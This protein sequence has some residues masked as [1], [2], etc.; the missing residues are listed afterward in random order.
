MLD[1]KYSEY[2]DGEGYGQSVGGYGGEGYSAPQNSAPA[3][4]PA[5]AVAEPIQEETPL[6]KEEPTLA[7]EEAAEPTPAEEPECR[8]EEPQQ[9]QSQ[10]EEP[11]EEAKGYEAQKEQAHEGFRGEQSDYGAGFGQGQQ[12]QRTYYSA[13]GRP[14]GGNGESEQ[15]SSY[16]FGG[17][18]PPPFGQN[19]YGDLFRK[20]Q[21]NSLSTL[22]LVCGLFSIIVSC[23][24]GIAALICGGFAI[25]FAFMSKS[26]NFTRKMD[27]AAQAAFVLAIIGILFGIFALSLRFF[28]TDEMLQSILE[29]VEST[30]STTAPIIGGEMNV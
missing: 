14:M 4:E 2:K 16:G 22:A 8:T 18:Q 7:Q 10:A 1:E 9:E 28:V 25:L 13:D 26:R 3:K 19:L 11:K 30:T 24:G 15:G 17:S 12:Q 27:T 29:Q 5:E 21:T 23:C 6:P 20:Q